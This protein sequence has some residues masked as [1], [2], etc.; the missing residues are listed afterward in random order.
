M[1]IITERT[2]NTP[3]AAIVTLGCPT[4]QVDSE[5]IMGGLVSLGFEIVPEEEADIA[6]VN[7]CG[8]IEDARA[9]SIEAIMSVAE[10][11]EHG[12]LK[13]LV[14]A[15]CLAERYREE[16]EDSLSEADAIVGLGER[17]KI[18][19]LCLNLLERE[20][21]AETPYSRVVTGPDNSAYLRIAEGCDNRCSYCAIPFIRGPFKSV[22]ME[23]ILA[24]ARELTDLGAHELMLVSQDTSAWGH[25]IGGKNLPGLL[26]KL[27]EIEK[28]D[29][30]RILY[31]NPSR[32]DDSLIDCMASM[33]KVIPYLDMPVQHI[34]AP[35]LKRMGRAADP[36]RIRNQIEKL[37]G[38]IDG[39]VL[40]TTVMTG[41]PGETDADFEEL[42]N[43]MHETRFERLGAFTYCPEEGTRAYDFEDTVPEEL[44]E[45]RFE[46]LMELQANISAEFHASL[47]GQEFDMIIDSA[48]EENGIV[49]GRTYMDAH[50][51]DGIVTVEGVVNPD[52]AFRR[53]KITGGDSYDMTGEFA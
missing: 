13:A 30:I 3:K 23:D 48:D 53:I 12:R 39:L 43:F 49:F 25:D 4:N 27:S 38:R 46:Q 33:P 42:L 32:I 17:S 28:V 2:K 16:L 47:A 37:R 45:E 20:T 40:R 24:D 41:F 51:I 6:V 9:E 31:A 36:D 14:V 50:D 5:R 10:L 15:G 19:A 52:E 21:P 34:A 18:P 29:W 22:P 8:F 11:K 44:A 26:E 1:S 7:T 35:V